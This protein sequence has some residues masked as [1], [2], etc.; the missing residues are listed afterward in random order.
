MSFAVDKWK[1]RC[2]LDGCDCSNV[3]HILNEV[4][5]DG[6]TLLGLATKVEYIYILNFIHY[7]VTFI[8]YILQLNKC[9]IVKYL[10]SKGASPNVMNKQSLTAYDMV[11]SDAMK[12]LYIDE[13]F[14][15][16]CKN[17]YVILLR[18]H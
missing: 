10:L 7:S 15:A 11:G 4:G 14:W 18:F 9:D 12:Q 8:F 5:P 17:K 16:V 2:Q 1:A 13:L 3:T 6:D